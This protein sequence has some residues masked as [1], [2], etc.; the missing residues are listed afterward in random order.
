MF[1]IILKVITHLAIMDSF[2]T[3]RMK[4]VMTMTESVMSDA[5]KRR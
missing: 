5:W 2:R 4:E 1:S 3:G